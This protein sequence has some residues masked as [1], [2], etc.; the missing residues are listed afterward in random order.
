MA[1]NQHT[2]SSPPPTPPSHISSY[3]DNCALWTILVTSSQHSQATKREQVGSW[4]DIAFD[5]GEETVDRMIY[6]NR[7]HQYERNKVVNLMFSDGSSRN[8][9][10]SDHCSSVNI[11]L[12]PPVTTSSV[13]LTVLSVYISKSWSNN[14]ARTIG[15]TLSSVPAFRSLE[16][17]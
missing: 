14:G 11:P 2:P 12:I 1:V 10:L 16:K 4:I 3:A 6:T 8:V 9:T 15:T 5:D 13:K 7:C 17:T